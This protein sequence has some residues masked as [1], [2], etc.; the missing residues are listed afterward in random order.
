MA[1]IQRASRFRLRA[2]WAAGLGVAAMVQAPLAAAQASVILPM[3]NYIVG[4]GELRGQAWCADARVAVSSR[5]LQRVV[6]EVEAFVAEAERRERMERADVEAAETAA[7]KTASTLRQALFNLARLQASGGVRADNPAI[8]AAEG[9][10]DAADKALAHRRGLLAR[11]AALTSERDALVA[12]PDPTST[13]SLGQVRRELAA[14][15]QAATAD[16]LN[17]GRSLEQLFAE[18]Q[19]GRAFLAA[20]RG[21]QGGP[22]LASAQQAVQDAHVADANATLAVDN[23]RH[24]QG[25]VTDWA[26][27]AR[28]QRDQ[29]RSCIAQ[30]RD[31]LAVRDQAAGPPPLNDP[32]GIGGQVSG[33]WSADCAYEGQKVNPR[34]GSFNLTFDGRGRIAGAF[35]EGM[36]VSVTGEVFADGTLRV[37]GSV[38]AEG[39]AMALSITGRVRQDGY[40]R[41]AAAGA[42]TNSGGG[43]VCKGGWG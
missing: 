34:S 5:A 12:D 20:E 17:T 22:A 15:E 33:Q 10:R 25:R 19:A 2:L 11:V 36:A 24:W 16:E 13:R 42:F 14:A 27:R 40:G 39:T 26:N 23:A 3:P 4:G 8:L 9:S 28:A 1:G 30:R 35:V 6:D 31:Q 21:R 43:V 38:V 7:R 37:D 41:V 29:A 18:A 32:R